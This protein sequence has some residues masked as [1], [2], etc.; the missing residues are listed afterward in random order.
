MRIARVV[1]EIVAWWALTFSVWMI[2]L[3]AAPVQEYLL[4][5]GCGLL[6]AVVAY[7][8]R[9]RALETSWVLRLRWLRPLAAVPLILV[10][11]ALQVLAAV[12]RP[13]QPGG[14]FQTVR[15]GAADATSEERSRRA[16]A[17]WMMSVTP[18]SY[19]LDYDEETGELLVHRLARRGPSM[20]RLVERS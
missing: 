9:R 16:V 17:A 18:G 13:G 20:A 11:D 2:S 3:S 15:T 6:C 19:A 10:T 1:A 12:V 5:A 8:A 14:E 7:V 4:A